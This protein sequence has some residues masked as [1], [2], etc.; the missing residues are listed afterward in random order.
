MNLGAWERIRERR[1]ARHWWTSRWAIALI[2]GGAFAAFVA[3]RTTANANA[4]GTAAA[5]MHAGSHAWLAVAL[6]TTALA[7]MRVPFHIYW[8]SD[9]ALLAQLPIGGDVL[10]AAAVRRC[11]RA[12]AATV[13]ACL[14]AAAP[15][16]ATL[17]V[18]LALRHVVLAGVLGLA[19]ACL[20]P[21]VATWA[22]MIVVGERG[23][24]NVAAAVGASRDDTPRPPGSA[25]AVLGA[26][27]GFV[28]AIVV[29]LVV[30]ASPWL[31]G[32]ESEALPIL[33]GLAA[34]SI[35]AIVV[36][37]ASAPRVMG[38]ILRDVSALDRQRLAKL[39]IE[40]PTAI[41]RAVGHLLGDAALPYAKDA[42]LMRRRYPM[43]FALGTFAFIILA[44][45]GLARPDDPT[46]W[47]VTIL[48]GSA[49]YGAALANRLRRPPIE[50][51]RLSA[52]LPI[53]PR[54]RALAKLAWV[55]AWATVY[56]AIPATFALLRS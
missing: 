29:V 40:P 30:L 56:L 16:F 44:I 38:A 43:A 35:V 32:G 45:V 34:A 20:L 41:E 5:G 27:P 52:T 12:A 49:L 48:V 17:P 47:L 33:G 1:E 13:L 21:A 37:R 6:T 19:A 55:V 23:V 4:N 22:A 50:L 2:S 10:F 28:S 26:L 3:W 24:L 9:A 15:L 31:I 7:F 11:M 18:G 46:P 42:R 39:E 53:E 8:R 14:V 25:S 51:S 54:A 36:A